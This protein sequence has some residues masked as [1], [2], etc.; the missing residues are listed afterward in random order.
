MICR[1]LVPW[2]GIEPT[3]LAVK[4]WI[5][6]HWTAGVFP[7]L[8]FRSEI[9]QI[10]TQHSRQTVTRFRRNRKC[11]KSLK[12]G[13]SEWRIMEGFTEEIAFGLTLLRVDWILASAHRRVSF[14]SGLVAKNDLDQG[15][16]PRSPAWQA[17]SLSLSYL[18]IKRPL[19]C[20][21]FWLISTSENL[22]RMTKPFL[23][24][25][26]IRLTKYFDH[27]YIAWLFWNVWNLLLCVTF[28][29]QISI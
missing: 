19:K 27:M 12:Q 26:E 17:D 16:E 18:R 15:I 25:N 24:L 29:S 20:M 6:N 28:D 22:L 2:P 1:I 4:A 10:D 3:T 14:K 21:T 5:P 7:C 11:R 9:R 23:G 13:K 8:Q